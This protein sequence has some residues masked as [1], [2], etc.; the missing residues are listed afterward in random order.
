MRGVSLS[1][2]GDL[3]EA[4]LLALVLPRYA[5]TGSPELVVAPG[6]DAAVLAGLGADVIATTDTMVR[7]IDWRDDWSSG[8]QVGRKL[9]A[10]NL[11]DIEA[12]GGRPVALLVALLADPQTEVAWVLDLADGIAAAALEAQVIVA[13]GDL[14]SAP[15][16]VV[17]A[18]VTALGTLDGHAPVLRSGAR[19]S[20]VLA[21]RGSLGFSGAGLAL[22]QAGEVDGRAANAEQATAAAPLLA[23]HRAPRV[24][25]GVG[26]GAAAA[27][28]S[29]LIDISDG[30]VRDVGRIASASGVGIDLDRGAL[31][32]LVTSTPLGVVLGEAEG[33]RQVLTGGEEHSL[34]G[35]FPGVAPQGWTPIGMVLA[36]S[37]VTLDG[38]PQ[39]HT[40]WDHFSP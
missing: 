17:V 34:V 27:G 33:L 13:G 22:L 20:D 9:V 35:C 6:D 37:G 25:P 38:V 8:A 7:G 16:G 24:E 26:A 28:A 1:R 14:S 4:E 10:Q 21:V 18:A 2:L 15:P 3:S 30:L 40:G 32:E 11:A 29:A 19:P 23:W 39:P 31:L 36:G 12:M 5:V